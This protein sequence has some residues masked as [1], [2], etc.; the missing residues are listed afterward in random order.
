[1]NGVVVPNEIRMSESL[2]SEEEHY[3]Y[4]RSSDDN[5]SQNSSR[6]VSEYSNEF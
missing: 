5:S 4:R 1:M 2:N 6:R 3:K